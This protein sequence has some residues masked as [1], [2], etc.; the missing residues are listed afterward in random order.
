MTGQR[1]RSADPDIAAQL[2]GWEIKRG[3]D[4]LMHAWLVGTDPPL[5]A[6]GEDETDLRD[7]IRAIAL[8]AQ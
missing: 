2:P 5:V 4:G 7:Q 3:N 8:R 6:S 1:P